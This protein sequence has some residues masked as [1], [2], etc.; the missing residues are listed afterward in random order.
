MPYYWNETNGDF[1]RRA[2]EAGFNFCGSFFVT[3]SFIVF[4]DPANSSLIPSA[5]ILFVSHGFL[6]RLRRIARFAF[7]PSSYADM[8]KTESGMGSGT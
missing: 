7:E 3:L 8:T 5:G 2:L 1:H 6:L 4:K